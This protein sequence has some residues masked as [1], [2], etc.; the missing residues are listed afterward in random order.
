MQNINTR[1]RIILVEKLKNKLDYV[2]CNILYS[3]IFTNL[4][5][6]KNDGM[7]GNGWKNSQK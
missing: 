3:S 2:Y 5:S 6:K 1:K 7:T 4:Y